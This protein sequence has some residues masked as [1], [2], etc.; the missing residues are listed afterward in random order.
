MIGRKQPII[1]LYFESDRTHLLS[2]AFVWH[3]T[4]YMYTLLMGSGG[5]LHLYGTRG[6]SHVAENGFRAFQK[7]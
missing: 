6:G 5:A 4:G 1:A 3:F 7:A 2:G